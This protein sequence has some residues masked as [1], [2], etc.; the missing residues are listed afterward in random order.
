MVHHFH[1]IDDSISLSLFF[2]NALNKINKGTFQVLLL[3]S[4]NP[5]I[6]TLI[7]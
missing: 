7:L 2:P 3:D 4:P 6:R 1:T 5:N